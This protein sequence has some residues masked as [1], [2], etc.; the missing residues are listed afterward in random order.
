MA[1]ALY[2]TKTLTNQALTARSWG[3]RITLP[4]LLPV[5]LITLLVLSACGGGGAAPTTATPTPPANP[6]ATNPFGDTCMSEADALAR[7]V[8]IRRCIIGR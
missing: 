2:T 3:N 8:I 5:L 7:D 4:V 1:N 6:C